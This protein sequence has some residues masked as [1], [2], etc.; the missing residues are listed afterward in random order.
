MRY[1]SNFA[2][3]FAISSSQSLD[4]TTYFQRDSI[5]KWIFISIF[6]VC[7]YEMF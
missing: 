2:Y 7:T 4:L 6:Y 1:C 3:S 5:P